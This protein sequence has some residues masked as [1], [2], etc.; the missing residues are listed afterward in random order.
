[1]KCQNCNTDIDEQSVYCPNCGIKVTET[2]STAHI[3][4]SPEGEAIPDSN[5]E[6]SSSTTSFLIWGIILSIGVW[7]IHGYLAST[8]DYR[9]NEFRTHFA[10]T[11]C[12]IAYVVSMVLLFTPACDKNY[13]YRILG[14]AALII[15][16]ILFLMNSYATL[17]DLWNLI[18]N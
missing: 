16:V 8:N 2:I 9:V 12:G 18:F 13:K 6:Q 1:M 5:E 3:S 17:C 7:L 15:A 11:V 14:I 10:N 4:A